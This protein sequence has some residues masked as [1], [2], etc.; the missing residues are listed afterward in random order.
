EIKNSHGREGPATAAQL[1]E[2]GGLHAS[3]KLNGLAEWYLSRA[4]E[5]DETNSQAHLSRLIVL[6]TGNTTGAPVGAKVQ[7]RARI[8]RSLDWLNANAP[9]LPETQWI[10]L[11]LDLYD[12]FEEREDQRGIRIGEEAI[13]RFPENSLLHFYTAF[14]LIRYG[15]TTGLPR[16]RLRQGQYHFQL[17]AELDPTNNIA[18]TNAQALA[19][20]L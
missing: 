1:A 3:L 10:A 18:A 7:W 16:E 13:R 17:A 12:C 11:W 6:I 14:A 5:L 2:L 15:Q 9:E 4:I 8:Q 19:Q 20:M